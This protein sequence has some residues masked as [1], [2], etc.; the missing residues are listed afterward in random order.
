MLNDI[1]GIFTFIGWDISWKAVNHS[2][3]FINNL[4]CDIFLN[5]FNIFSFKLWWK[6]L[7]YSVFW[8]W[9]CLNKMDIFK[10]YPISMF[11]FSITNA[12]FVFNFL[13]NPLYNLLLFWVLKTPAINC[14]DIKIYF[15]LYL[16]K[17]SLNLDAL[18]F[19]AN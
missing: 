7:N 3:F 5:K 17:I 19:S 13:F 8:G 16:F 9:V 10:G 12:V 2:I 18:R 11:S 1:C 14:W 6:E 15:F 4:K